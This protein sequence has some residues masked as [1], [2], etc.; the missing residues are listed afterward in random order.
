MPGFAR[1]GWELELGNS[2]PAPESLTTAT[3][4]SNR[5]RNRSLLRDVLYRDDEGDR[6]G[7]PERQSMS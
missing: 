1:V 4:R 7:S 3:V 6:H 2:P 5:S